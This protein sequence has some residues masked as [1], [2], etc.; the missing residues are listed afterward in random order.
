MT[1]GFLALRLP[2]WALC[3]LSSATC[4]VMLLDDKCMKRLFI[5]DPNSAVGTGPF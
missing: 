5:Y 3:R 2:D 4:N 1:S